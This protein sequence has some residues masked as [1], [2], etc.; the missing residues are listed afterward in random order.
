MDTALLR[1]LV[2]EDNPADARMVEWTLAHEPDQKFTCVKVDRVATALEQI[3]RSEVDAVFIDMGLPDSNGADGVRRIRERAPGAAVVV[4][5]GSEDPLLVVG[6]VAEG[7]QD[8]LIKGIF[9]PGHLTRILHGA[10]LRQR[11]EFGL[12]EG[13]IPDPTQLLTRDLPGQGAIIFPSHRPPA[14]NPTFTEI[15]GLSADDLRVCPTWL[16]QT[17]RPTIAPAPTAVRGPSAA[18][19][20]DLPG[21]VLHTRPDGRKVEL[22]FVARRI[23]GPEGARV[24][25]WVR[26][27]AS[28]GPPVPLSAGSRAPTA[29]ANDA[30]E[31]ATQILPPPYVGE[32]PI[33]AGS[34]VQ[35]RLLAGRDTT[36]LPALVDA[37]VDEERRLVRR[38]EVAAGRGDAVVLVQIAHNLKSTC[39]QVGALRLSRR[40]ADLEQQGSMVSLASLRAAVAGISGEMPAVESALAALRIAC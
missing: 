27:V 11:V 16:E 35:L 23:S 2:V 15:T 37:F 36:F 31:G 18:A 30:I 22:E 25:V 24:L 5:S 10:I 6:A 20:R 8:Y 12:R 40:C 26:E 32:S 39:A 19:A 17:V 13:P 9:P 33:D 34:W 1:V 21:R 38:L 4:L 29:V 3:G 28:N 7:A 14:V